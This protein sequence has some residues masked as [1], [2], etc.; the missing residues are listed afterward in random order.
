MHRK[1]TSLMLVLTLICSVWAFAGGQGEEE[2]QVETQTVER[3]GKYAES[4]ILKKL[5]DA[6]ELPPVD[7]RVPED[8]MVVGSGTLFPEEDLQFEIGKY[9]GTM[10]FTTANTSV[11]AEL[12]DANNEPLLRTKPGMLKAGSIADVIPNVFKDYEISDDKTTVTF[13]MRKG[14]KWSDGEPVTTEDIRFTYEDV[15]LNKDI[16]DVLG[17]DYRSGGV[18]SG[19][20]LKLEVI[21]D[22]TFRMIADKPTLKLVEFLGRFGQT[23][24]SLLLPSH[25]LKQFHKKYADPDKFA[26]FLKEENLSE[27]EWFRLFELKN[28][29]RLHWN[30][31][32]RQSSDCPTLEPWVLENRS[33]NVVTFVRNPYYWKVDADGNQLPY[34]DK[35]RIEVLSDSEAVTLKMLAG[36]VSWMREYASMTNLH[37]YKENEDRGNFR[38]QPLDMHVAPLAMYFNMSYEDETW[39]E[40]VQDVRFRKAMNIAINHEQIVDL[41][42]NGFGEVP[43]MIPAQYDP[44][45]AKA[46]LDEMGLDEMDGEGFRLGPDGKRFILPIQAA[47]GFTPEQDDLVELLVQYWQDVGIKADYQTMSRSLFTEQQS[48]N[49]HQFR[50]AWAPSAFWRNTPDRYGWGADQNVAWNDWWTSNGARG[51]EPPQWAKRALEIKDMA[52]TYLLSPEK[53]EELQEEQFK[54]I[55]ER[56][57][58]VMPIDHGQYP[59]VVSN[60][61]GNIPTGGQAIMASWT[62]E[63]FFFK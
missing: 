2:Q 46:L 18:P 17:K 63:Q 43:D 31:L 5:V 33:S 60:E 41:V 15:K 26:A 39:R 7:D 55:R 11:C 50:L 34:I 51:E 57:P 19:D 1:I 37:L 28:E 12:Y 45:A 53:M 4:P 56:I 36:E 59:I 49:E 32:T 44:E 20:P 54:I 23:F 10:Q 29:C 9:G 61:L 16:T 24:D 42:Y 30:E 14:M 25:Y 58:F 38:V 3:T 22:Y 47:T 40:V 6:G 27:E 8:P 21:D 52:A 48:A 13:H 35:L 62:Q